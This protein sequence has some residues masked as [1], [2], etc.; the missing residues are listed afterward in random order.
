MITVYGGFPSRSLRVIWALEELGLE[1]NLRPVD[2]RKRMEDADSWPSTRPDFFQQ[3][4]TAMW[5]WSI[6]SPSSNI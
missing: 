1:Y 3:C 2:L 4:G 6:P 5:R